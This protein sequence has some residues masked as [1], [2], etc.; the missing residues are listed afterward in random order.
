[1]IGCD[2]HPA[3]LGDHMS[4]R[5]GMAGFGQGG[6]Y[7]SVV[8]GTYDSQGNYTPSGSASYGSA[9]NPN[10]VT[11]QPVVSPAAGPGGLTGTGTPASITSS[12]GLTGADITS[13]LSAIGSV[14]TSALRLAAIAKSGQLQSD[15]YG[16]SGF[17]PLASIPPVV[18]IG[19]LA[20]LVVLVSRK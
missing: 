11:P 13:D 10:A 20:L 16:L 3:L 17:N 6:D 1:M 7:G 9:T 2:C 15:L 18:L 19:G 8:T 14:A 4:T 12:G 5:R